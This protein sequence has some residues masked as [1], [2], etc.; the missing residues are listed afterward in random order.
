MY[1]CYSVCINLVSNVIDTNKL[2][3]E[4][5]ATV[6]LFLYTIIAAEYTLQHVGILIILF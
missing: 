5:T 6:K 2:N 1:I 3:I 4:P